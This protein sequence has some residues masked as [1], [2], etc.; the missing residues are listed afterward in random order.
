MKLKILASPKYQQ[1]LF[2]F[3]AFVAMVVASFWYVR[4]IIQEQ[5]KINGDEVMISATYTVNSLLSETEV[6]LVGVAYA[7]KNMISQGA[8]A[9]A[10][11]DYLIGLSD[12]YYT[13]GRDRY[14]F[15][16]GIYGQI[17]GQFIDGNRW[18]PPDGY[19]PSTRPWYT[20][21]MEEPGRVVYTDPYVDAESNKVVI[22]VSQVIFDRRGHNQGV[23]SLDF[24]MTTVSNHIK[25]L[26]VA[27]G[28]YGVMFN[29][30]LEV[31]THRDPA[32][33][34]KKLEE[35]G[36]GYAQLAAM[37]VSGEE[38]S[39]VPI[40]D[41]DGTE[42]VV[43]L[44]N[45]FNGWGVGVITPLSVY[46][47]QA[48]SMA[49]VMSLLAAFLV[50]MLSTILWRLYAAKD[51]AD[52]KNQSKSSFLARMSH[53]IR[54][55][56][57]AIVGMSE[58]IL[59]DSGRLPLKT[60]NYALGIKQ[61]SA[62]L[63]TII[64]DILDFSKIESGRFELVSGKY[65]L[66]SLLHDVI[67]IIRMRIREKPLIFMADIDPD[68][69]ERLQGDEV[70]VRQI[71]LNLLS[72]AAKYTNSGFIRLAMRGRRNEAGRL[73]L[74]IEVSDSGIGIRKEAMD[75]LFG[76]YIRI[77]LSLNRGVE[78]TGL[79]LAI[80]RNLCRMMG[81]DIAV[82]SEHGLGS[83]FTA[84]VVQDIDGEGCL[85]KVESPED[86][87]VLV[88]EPVV[89]Y[90]KSV[91]AALTGLSVPHTMVDSRHRFLDELS[92]RDYPFIFVSV[93]VY[94]NL[95]G[96]IKRHGSHSR[97]VMLSDDLD[98]S[99]ALDA[100]HINMPAYSLPIANILNNVLE[101]SSFYGKKDGGPRYKFPKAQIL[102]VDDIKTNLTVAEG[103]L[104]PY[105]VKTD[106]CLNG[107]TA[108]ELIMANNYDLVFMDHI[109]PGLDGL[110]ATTL[111]RSLEDG[112]FKDLPI[113]ALTA[114]AISGVREMYL[115]NGLNDFLPKPI[116]AP[117]LYSMLMRWIPAEK[118]VR[119]VDDS[120]HSAAQAASREHSSREDTP[121]I[122]GLDTSTAI[123]RIGGDQSLYMELI[124]IFRV[125]G[126][127]R[128]TSLENF[129]SSGDVKGYT[130]CVHALK[131]ALGSIGA[132]DLSMMASELERAGSS[133]D[134]RYIKNNSASFLNNLEDLIDVIDDLFN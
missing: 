2:V 15:F 66:A 80:S 126:R 79:G 48:R 74:T 123:D 40:T 103:L 112:R 116:E 119:A 132:R 36:P 4:E 65:A 30:S 64:N 49:A 11:D 29:D 124:D 41:Y 57:N 71:V 46:Y 95:R 5:M 115:E 18:Q 93:S 107:N 34:G 108:I 121:V 6:T 87:A 131:G 7:L 105:E 31:V 76:D 61:A 55:P 16:N 58:L 33:I 12:W 82:V 32:L 69:P 75:R 37:M 43:F 63:L 9:Q 38:I 17:M 77:D 99:D 84:T 89:L 122:A 53:E 1:I 134:N 81:G 19:D 56:M 133:G 45:L 70:R 129:L 62:N 78:G 68:L 88:Y 26:K 52:E 13:A 50:I 47:G 21:A 97:L 60:R 10:L 111:I 8:D 39:A 72:N 94:N 73:V 128:I 102:V 67:S 96:E 127:E 14:F 91:S 104:S 59:R 25:E 120:D 86:K 51:S 109:M 27:D 20:K 22:S 130:I 35:L 24:D 23:L 83:T 92:R 85:A 106:L 110:E 28:G 54:T 90:A 117:E 118:R 100:R 42:S 101:S 125:D 3:L 114:N 98:D 113:V 44:T